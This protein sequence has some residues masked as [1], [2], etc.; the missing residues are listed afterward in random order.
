MITPIE[1]LSIE[2]REILAQFM[3]IRHCIAP[4]SSA[5]ISRESV[6]TNA[7]T[8]RR[9]RAGLAPPAI[10]SFAQKLKLSSDSPFHLYL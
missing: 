1:S 9:R 4:F 5:K 8:G 10:R 3:P 2:A 6:N 7:H